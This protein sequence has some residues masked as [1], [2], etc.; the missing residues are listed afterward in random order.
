MSDASVR[1]HLVAVIGTVVGLEVFSETPKAQP[2]VDMAIVTDMRS[3][4][5]RLTLTRPSGRKTV[6]YEVDVTI[7]TVDPD[8]DTARS[9][10]DDL[11]WKVKHALRTSAIPATLTDATSGEVSTLEMLDDF[12]VIAESLEDLTGDDEVEGNLWAGALMRIGC[13]EVVTA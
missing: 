5:R 10:L 12:D 11:V 3:R 4:E 7:A 8:E 9:N 1:A 13:R 2:L 6:E